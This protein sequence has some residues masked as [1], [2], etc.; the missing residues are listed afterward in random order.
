MHGFRRMDRQPADQWHTKHRRAVGKRYLHLE[1]HRRGREYP[2]ISDGLN[3]RAGRSAKRLSML[4]N[5]W[6]ADVK[7]ERGA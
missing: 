3:H 4:G 5:E 1:L 6:F 7:G 2:A